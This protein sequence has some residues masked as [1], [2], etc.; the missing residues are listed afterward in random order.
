MK[1]VALALALLLAVGSQAASLQAD[2]PSKLEHIRAAADVYLNQV[3]D[4]ANR[5][6][7]QLDD[8]E[9]KDLK[10]TLS[11]RLDEMYNHIKSLQS[12]VAPMTDS[13]VATIADATAD[14]RTSFMADIDALKTELEPQCEKLREV[15]N[16]HIEEYRVQL[17]PIINDYYTKHTAEMETLKAK[18]DTVAE[19]LHAKVT[20][21]VEETKAVLM[22]MV[23]SVRTKLAERLENLKEMATPY[24]E[25]YKEQLKQAYSQAQSINTDEVSA[26]RQKIT[27][28]AE[29][30]KVKLQAIF[31]AIAATVTK[32]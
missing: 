19:D 29:E 20:T 27:P 6:L 12:S 22:P 11:G 16:R 23:E 8:T 32:S 13:V 1:F 7:D 31:E 18:M 4:S 5:A 3:K 10:V 14:A 25:E 2:S 9:Y 30:V 17:E 15:I 28:L 24:V 26:L 21:N